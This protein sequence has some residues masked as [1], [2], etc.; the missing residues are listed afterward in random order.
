MNWNSQDQ[1]IPLL[2]SMGFKTKT[3]DKKTGESKD[4]MVEKLIINQKVLM[5]SLLNCIMMIIRRQLKFVVPM[6]NNI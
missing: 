1:V 2:Q 6:D 3:E 5:M 4:S